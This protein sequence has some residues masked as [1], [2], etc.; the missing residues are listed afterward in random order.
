MK[1]TSWNMRGLGS[2]RRQRML[3]YKM[4]QEMSDMIFIQET[5]CSIHKLKLIHGKWLNRFEFL[6]V[7][8]ENTARGILTL[9]NPQKVSIIDAEASRNYLS[10]VIQPVGVSETFL[11]TNVYDPQRIDDKLKLLE[12]LIDLRKRHAGI[13][14]IMGELSNNLFTWNDKRGGEAHVA[15]KLD[16]FMISEELMLIDKEISA[17]V[18]PFGGSDHSPIQ[19][20]IKGMVS[21]GNRPLRFENIWLSHRDFTSNIEKWWS[22]DLQFQG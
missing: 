12:S 6:E 13:P 5:K 8:A 18:L 19:L 22:K 16:R 1:F 10:V 20:E 15:S 7:N 2:K 14:C 3:S 4:K 11:V 17:R 9:W 21:H